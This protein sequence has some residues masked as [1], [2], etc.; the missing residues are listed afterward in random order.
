MFPAQLAVSAVVWAF[1]IVRLARGREAL[2]SRA[3]SLSPG[4]R[5][6]SAILKMIASVAV[7][8]LG[9]AALAHG[10]LT[11]GGLTWWGWPLITLVGAAFIVLQTGALV[12]LVL[13]AVQPVTRGGD[14]SSD[15]MDSNRP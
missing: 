9:M 4:A 14:E 13:N 11:P 5:A 7:L 6:R 15:T 10:G 3:A 2:T 12:P 8:A 1:V